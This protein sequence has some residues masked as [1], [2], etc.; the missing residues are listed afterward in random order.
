MSIEEFEGFWSAPG[1]AR[2][3]MTADRETVVRLLD[4]P[5]EPAGAVA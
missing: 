3:R 2:E 1:A 4:A 5:G